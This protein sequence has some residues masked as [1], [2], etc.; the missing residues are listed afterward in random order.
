MS[1]ELIAL[2]SEIAKLPPEKQREFLIFGQGL[3]AGVEL[4]EAQKTA[5]T[6]DKE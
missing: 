3:V 2:V 5:E 4:A 6:K 1:P